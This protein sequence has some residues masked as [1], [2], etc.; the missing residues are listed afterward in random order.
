MIKI[1]PDKEEEERQHKSD[2]QLRKIG[3]LIWICTG[4]IF[5]II[6]IIETNT[7]SIDVKSTTFIKAQLFPEGSPAKS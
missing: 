4:L 2:L 5:L 3:R 7:Y 1:Y 6:P